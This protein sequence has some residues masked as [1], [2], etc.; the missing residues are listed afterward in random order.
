M[1]ELL[2][3]VLRKINKLSCK[4]GYKLVPQLLRERDRTGKGEISMQRSEG[5]NGSGETITTKREKRFRAQT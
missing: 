2:K 5:K 4:I 1:T 3:K